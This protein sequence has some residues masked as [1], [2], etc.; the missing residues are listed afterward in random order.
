MCNKKENGYS[1][2][3]RKGPFGEEFNL[4]VCSSRRKWNVLLINCIEHY[5]LLSSWLPI[6]DIF[7]YPS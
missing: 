5:F 6:H 7:Y 1:C 4:A 2:Q 3:S